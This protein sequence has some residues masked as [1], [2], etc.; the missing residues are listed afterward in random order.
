MNWKTI[1]RD[2]FIIFGITFL[3]AFVVEIA[4]VYAPRFKLSLS[5]TNVVFTIVGFTISGALTP[6]DRFRHLVKVAVAV[7]ILSLIN[8]VFSYQTFIQWFFGILF[9]LICMAVGGALS[10]VFAKATK[11]G[12]LEQSG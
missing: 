9:L 11:P 12:G 1:L 7:W 5:A 3:A 2:A 10:F 4:G 8:V 6:K